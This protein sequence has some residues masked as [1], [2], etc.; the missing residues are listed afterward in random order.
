MLPKT[1]FVFLLSTSLSI[2]GVPFYNPHYYDSEELSN[3]L[4][5]DVD[6]NGNVKNESINAHG[7]NLMDGGAVSF[8]N[9]LIGPKNCLLS[10]KHNNMLYLIS[11][12]SGR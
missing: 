2:C 6:T 9:D 5:S 3:I 11:N 4:N 10:I 7:S 1:S 8:L 12:F